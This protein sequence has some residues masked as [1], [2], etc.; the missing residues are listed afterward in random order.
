MAYAMLRL[1]AGSGPSA[2]EIEAM[3]QRERLPDIRNVPGFLRIATIQLN[4]G[5]MGTIGVFE[6]RD[7]AHKAHTSG[8]QW[9][10]RSQS[11]QGFKLSEQME[12]DVLY[13]ITGK[14]DLSRRNTVG[15]LRI[16]QPKGSPDEVSRLIQR[17]SRSHG[18]TEDAA[19]LL[20]FTVINLTDG[21]IVVAAAY[22]TQEL[23]EQYSEKL[24]QARRNPTE[25]MRALLPTDPETYQ[26]RKLG[27]YGR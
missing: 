6:D 13:G 22:E 3:W 19:G 18:L 8:N 16:Y 1:F 14:G 9:I 23:Y 27:F 5:R 20:R 11:L 12:G 10:E 2:D 25:E 15:V 4:D 24:L 7:A 17:T 21:R 26:G